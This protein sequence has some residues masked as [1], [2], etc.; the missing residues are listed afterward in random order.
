MAMLF[1]QF[2]TH[3]MYSEK[4]WQDGCIPWVIISY[5]YV[6]LVSSMMF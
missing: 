3:K 1:K 2:L 6:L 4:F 5:L